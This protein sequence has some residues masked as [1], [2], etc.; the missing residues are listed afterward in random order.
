MQ[1]MEHGEVH[2]F[3]AKKSCITFQVY[4]S[5]MGENGYLLDRIEGETRK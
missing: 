3:A 5:G 4:R 2:I 1:G